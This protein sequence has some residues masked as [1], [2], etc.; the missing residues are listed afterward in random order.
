MVGVK[1]SELLLCLERLHIRPANR[2]LACIA[3]RPMGVDRDRAT[4][5]RVY[6]S[7]S[8]GRRRSNPWYDIQRTAG[9][10]VGASTWDFTWEHG[11]RRRQH[12]VLAQ[13]EL[14]RSLHGPETPARRRRTCTSQV[15][16][17]VSER[18]ARLP[19]EAT[20]GD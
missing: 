1:L 3:N 9:Q 16:R 6:D 19:H 17:R 18:G 14:A 4:G 10:K 13:L 8:W 2:Q 11:G 7:N 15:R 12:L 5:L 20:D